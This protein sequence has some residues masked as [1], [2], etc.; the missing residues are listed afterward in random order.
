MLLP[1]RCV[2]TVVDP[3]DTSLLT[4]LV[5]WYYFGD[6]YPGYINCCRSSIPIVA[7][8]SLLIALPWRCVP[9][10]QKLLYTLYTLCCPLVC[11][12]CITLEMCTL[13]TQAVVDPIYTL[14]PPGVPPVPP[15]G[16]TL[17]MCTLD[18]QFVVD[19]RCTFLSPGLS[20]MYY[21]GDVYPG[22]T[23][24]CRPY[25]HF[26]APWYLLM[27][28]LGNVYPGYTNCCRS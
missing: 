10:I 28:I 17:E 26:V 5:L 11:P 22:Y 12:Y 27:V 25:M 7:P 23:N 16:I 21:L 19:H 20:L 3:R 13:D 4:G 24:C 2:Q 15:Y 18:T 8:W 1:W 9:W 14:L 6:V